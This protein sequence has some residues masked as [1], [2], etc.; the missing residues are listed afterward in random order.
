MS[1][2]VITYIDGFNLYFGM[3]DASMRRFYWLNIET[4]SKRILKEGQLLVGVK[5]FTSRIT[6]KVS[7][8]SKVKR[9]TTY[10]EALESMCNASIFWGDYKTI[11]WKCPSC[12]K[13][14]DFPTE[15]QTDVNI[16]TEMILDAVYDKYDTAILISA[17][18]DLVA[19]VKAIVNSAWDKR[20]VAAF[21]PKRYSK[22]LHDAASSPYFITRSL[23]SRSQLPPTVIKA[24]GYK[25]ERPDYWR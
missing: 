25:L 18:S 20:V 24:D 13:R 3:K 19:P 10:L 7:R 5:Y 22:E 9:Q 1:E 4:L 11:P 15:K 8:D 17:D 2:R 21:P 14:S 23:L 6:G 16:A 12:H